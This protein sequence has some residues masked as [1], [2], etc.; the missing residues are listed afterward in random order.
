MEVKGLYHRLQVGQTAGDV[1]EYKNALAGL[2]CCCSEYRWSFLYL[3][4]SVS[5]VPFTACVAAAADSCEY[6]W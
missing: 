6:T 2:N 1:G 4:F 3:M 5:P